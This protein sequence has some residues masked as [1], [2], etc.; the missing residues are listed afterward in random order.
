MTHVADAEARLADAEA[1]MRR[2][3]RGAEERLPSRA[4]RGGDA[5]G[6]VDVERR[7][8]ASL[9]GLGFARARGTARATP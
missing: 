2:G 4:G 6:G 9:A 3:E 5:A 1:R 8:A 7:V